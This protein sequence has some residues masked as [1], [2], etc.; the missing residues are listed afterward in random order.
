MNI[1]VIIIVA[2]AAGLVILVVLPKVRGFARA[3]KKTVERRSGKDRR[4]R[5]LRL[6]MERRRRDRRTE[7]AAQAFVEGLAE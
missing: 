2:L 7:D 3:E 6:P 1:A 4:W 5:K